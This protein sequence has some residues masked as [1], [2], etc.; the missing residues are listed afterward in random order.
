MNN[1]VVNDS[2]I[3]ER[4]KKD[5]TFGEE[6]VKILT[7]IFNILNLI[8]DDKTSFIDKEVL[9]NKKEDINKLFSQIK[10]FHTSKIWKNITLAQEQNKH[11]S[12]IRCV[13]KHH[14]YI[15]TFKNAQ[16][17]REDIK[18]VM[19]RYFIIKI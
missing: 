3:N 9:E 18:K 13:L 4:P 1:D 16:V 14:G 10:K 12:I 5:T 7:S 8:P 17:T 11:M 15:F 6:Q 2:P 19:Q